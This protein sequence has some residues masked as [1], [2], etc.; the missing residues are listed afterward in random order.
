MSSVS[1]EKKMKAV[2]NESADAAAAADIYHRPYEGEYGTDLAGDELMKKAEKKLKALFGGNNRFE[3]V[4]ELYEAA[5]KSYV[6][7]ENWNEATESFVKAAELSETKLQSNFNAAAY[8]CNAASAASNNDTA[9]AIELY[10]LA[11]SLH[12]SNARIQQAAK[13]WRKV[14]QLYEDEEK[15]NEA[16]E[17]YEKAFD[18]HEAEDTMTNGILLLLLIADLH[19]KNSNWKPAAGIYERVA[20][21]SIEKNVNKGSIHQYLYKALLCWLLL[22]VQKFKIKRVKQKLALYYN[23]NRRYEGTREF[24]LIEK[25]IAA[26]EDED[27]E[28]FTDAIYQ[29]NKQ[30]PLES[31]ESDML[32]RMKQI[33][34]AG[35][36]QEEE[37]EEVD[38]R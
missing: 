9:R 1:G 28:K 20:N 6:D 11:V 32:L 8:Y 19:I 31:F 10:Q 26:C 17:A 12:M 38:M 16:I 29:Y 21:L 37:E 30:K 33:L 5:G 35:P 25:C 24:V 7:A 3:K 23:Q 22:D 36:S 13:V 15:I 4:C 2:Q 18:C 14:G 34:K 27:V